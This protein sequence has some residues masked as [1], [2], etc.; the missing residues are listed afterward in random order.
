MKKKIEF[1]NRVDSDEATQHEPPHFN[2]RCLP[3]TFR[4]QFFFYSF[5]V[6]EEIGDL[7]F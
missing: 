3:L 7:N 4:K 6:F 1:T 5:L 2:L